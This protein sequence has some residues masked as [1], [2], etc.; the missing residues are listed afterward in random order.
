MITLSGKNRHLEESNCQVLPNCFAWDGIAHHVSRPRKCR[1]F[2]YVGI[3]LVLCSH[4]QSWIWNLPWMMN[5]YMTSFIYN[6]QIFPLQSDF[7][8]CCLTSARFA[9][10]LIAWFTFTY[11]SSTL[12]HT[13]LLAASVIFVT[14][15]SICC[16]VNNDDVTTI[17]NSITKKNNTCMRSLCSPA[18]QCLQYKAVK[19]NLLDGEQQLKQTLRSLQLY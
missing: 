15:M 7:L 13:L 8:Y 11:R 9:M 3:I 17:G 19:T 4:R 18:I 12:N 1:L 5:T 16:R 2:P 10:S 14:G 6:I